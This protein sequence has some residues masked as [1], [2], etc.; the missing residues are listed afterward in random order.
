M[1]LALE[2]GPAT[3]DLA[4]ELSVRGVPIDGDT[5][6]REGTAALAPLRERGLAPCQIGAFFFNPL[7]PDRSARS[8]ASERI[9]SL[10]PL[11]AEIGCPYIAFAAGSRAADIFGGAHPGNLSPDALSEAAATLEPLARM[12]ERQGVCLTLEPHLRSVLCTPERGA[13]L[14]SLVGSNALRVTFD[15]TNFYDFMDLLA[16]DS[17]RQRCESALAPCC[18]MVHFKEIALAAGFHFHA[19]LAPMGTGSTDWQA[20]LATAEKI[21]PANSW[22]L[23]EHCS[24]AEEAR[25]SIA[26]VRQAAAK[27][28]LNL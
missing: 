21:A 6:L 2:A 14:C 11:A 10:I 25:A 23:V 28:G 18:G 19:G 15:V 24:S 8:A 5:L 12:A 7:D 27:L 9:A 26:L 20:V 22:L 1:K 3:L 16:P 4:R 17:M 13:A